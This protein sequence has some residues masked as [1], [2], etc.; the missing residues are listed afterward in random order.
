[1][2]ILFISIERNNR[3]DYL[4]LC[5]YM[6]I[7]A[8]ACASRYNATYHI[9][10]T[11]EFIISFNNFNCFKYFKEVKLVIKK[12]LSI[13][14]SQIHLS[15]DLFISLNCKILLAIIIYWIF[16][17][18]KVKVILLIIRELEKKYIDENITQS[19]YDI[20]KDYNI[21]KNLRYFIINNINNNGFAL[22]ELNLLIIQD[23]N[24]KFDSIK[25]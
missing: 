14:H 6:Y 13:A 11:S 19:I 23:E 21:I 10:H 16:S 20:I 17:I 4:W 18:Y 24:I 3:N 15:F 7:K 2:T 9:T 8:D 25:R 12:L 22:K 1:M 5:Y